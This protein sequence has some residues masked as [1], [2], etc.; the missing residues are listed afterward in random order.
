MGRY[1]PQKYKKMPAMRAMETRR[2]ATDSEKQRARLGY[3]RYQG[4]HESYWYDDPYYN[5]DNQG[6]RAGARFKKNAARGGGKYFALDSKAAESSDSKTQSKG[7]KKTKDVNGDFERS[8]KAIPDISGK[9]LIDEREGSSKRKLSPKAKSS[10]KK[11][12]SKT[13]S[14]AKRSRKQSKKRAAK[15]GRGKPKKSS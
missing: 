4:K 6:Q 10:P 1:N 8:Y 2:K 11:T 15:K 12:V 7:Q 13:K 14:G 9:K 3:G 5:Q